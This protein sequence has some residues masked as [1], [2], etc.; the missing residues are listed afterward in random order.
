MAS[1]SQ[2]YTSVPNLAVMQNAGV[3]WENWCDCLHLFMKLEKLVLGNISLH[4]CKGLRTVDEE[5]IDFVPC[6]FFNGMA[7]KVSFSLSDSQLCFA[8]PLQRE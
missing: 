2:L 4:P 7:L 5:G 6:E 3:L 8:S 1:T